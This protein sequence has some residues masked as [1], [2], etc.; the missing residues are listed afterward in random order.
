MENGKMISSKVMEFYTTKVL[1]LY[2]AN[3]ISEIWMK[4]KIIGLSTK[5][6]LY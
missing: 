4:L 6:D 1:N 2:K 5:V 3:S